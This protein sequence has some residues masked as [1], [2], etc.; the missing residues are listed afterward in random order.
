MVRTF[1]YLDLSLSHHQHHRQIHHPLSFARSTPLPLSWC[2]VRL[3]EKK[4]HRFS[5]VLFGSTPSLF[6]VNIRVFC[7]VTLTFFFNLICIWVFSGLFSLI[8]F[9]SLGYTMK[10]NFHF[11]SKFGFSFQ[12]LQGVFAPFLPLSISLRPLDLL[13]FLSLPPDLNRIRRNNF[14]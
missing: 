11:S 8:I 7:C 5:Y 14:C 4:K 1:P 10:W 6:V 2:L 13:C 12:T 3:I 9:L